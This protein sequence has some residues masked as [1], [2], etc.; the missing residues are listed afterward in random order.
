MG[1]QTLFQPTKALLNV[2][3]ICFVSQMT[4][5]IDTKDLIGTRLGLECRITFLLPNF[6]ELI[7]YLFLSE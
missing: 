4:N 2:Y 3:M 7:F 1:V 5:G 6:S